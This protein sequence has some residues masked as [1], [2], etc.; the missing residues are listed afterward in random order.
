MALYLN[1]L[2]L[3][4][5]YF[6]NSIEEIE[7]LLNVEY[8]DFGLYAYYYNMVYSI[9]SLLFFLATIKIIIFSKLYQR[10]A[11]VYD[12]LEI[13]FTVFLKYSVFFIFFLLG[14]AIIYNISYGPYMIEFSNMPS[15]II[16]IMLMTLGKK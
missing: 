8:F 9:E 10:L 3:K 15:S 13:G 14:F 12:T 1:A 6:S 5:E 11:F 2:Y 4:L 16:Q 7:D